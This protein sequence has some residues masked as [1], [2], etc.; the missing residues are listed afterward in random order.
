MG[1]VRKNKGLGEG[2]TGSEAQL[3]IWLELLG[4]LSR[5]RLRAGCRIKAIWLF[6]LQNHCNPA[7]A[8]LPAL[9]PHERAAAPTRLEE[10]SVHKQSTC[11]VLAVKDTGW[12]ERKRVH[13]LGDIAV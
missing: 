11:S 13:V 5:Y 1:R 6:L 3:G 2:G 12:S 7:N 9:Q 10:P 8:F 4:A